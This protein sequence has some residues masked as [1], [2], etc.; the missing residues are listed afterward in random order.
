MHRHACACAG[1]AHSSMQPFLPH[2]LVS[3]ALPC[4]RHKSPASVPDPPRVCGE[5][6]LFLTSS[7]QNA[8]FACHMPCEEIFLSSEPLP[9]P[10]CLQVYVLKV[11]VREAATHCPSSRGCRRKGVG[12]AFFCFGGVVGSPGVCKP[13]CLLKNTGEPLPLTPSM[14]VLFASHAPVSC[15]VQFPSYALF[16]HFSPPEE[17]EIDRREKIRGEGV[18]RRVS[19]KRAQ[20]IPGRFSVK[21]LFRKVQ[22]KKQ[23]KWRRP[24]AGRS[25]PL[26]ALPLWG[27]QEREVP[28]LTT[29]CQLRRK[30]RRRCCCQ[31]LF[32]VHLQTQREGVP[33]RCFMS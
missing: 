10:P 13:L 19:L 33:R 22:C 8:L 18:Q 6:C 2:W 15:P 32:P 25:P 1:S 28:L 5:H 17:E 12:D 26:P 24:A 7:S 29:K 30:F 11:Y 23:A 14:P 27:S 21:F 31:E 3:S 16:L 9:S 20:D 4:Q